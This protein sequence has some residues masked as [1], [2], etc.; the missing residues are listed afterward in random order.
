MKAIL[1]LLAAYIAFIECSMGDVDP[2]FRKCRNYC[3]YVENCKTQRVDETNWNITLSQLVRWSCEEQCSY[4]CM[5][6]I[7][8]VRISNN[9]P[10]LKYFGHWPFERYWG[11]EEPA[12]VVF[13]ILN[14]IPHLAYLVEIFFKSSETNTNSDRHYMFT[15]LQ[16]YAL[17][18]CNAWFASTLFHS[19][20]TSTTTL[21]DYMS[22]LVF[23]TCG[24][25]VCVRRLLGQ[26]ASGRL[27]WTIAISVVSLCGCRL[28]AMWIGTVSFDSHMQAC[29][30]LVIVTTC[31]WTLWIFL[32]GDSSPQSR[33]HR[34]LCLLCQVWLLLA[35]AL[36]VFDFP[37][38]WRTFD[39]HSL[40]HAATVP[41]G[42]LWYWA[43]WKRDLELLPQEK[44]TH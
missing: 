23:L 20:K 38:F 39:A 31:F 32:S 29:I 1:L 9:R 30:A 27:V 25:G 11:L 35:S 5:T 13:S 14:F 37:P 16:F 3:Y 41:L 2:N 28:R 7:T 17:S 42:F 15:W 36:E 33:R 22:A 40:W 44:K 26:K 18:A 10:V 6:E 12:S 43:F 8:K 4:S 19:H 21:Y 24:L 34:G